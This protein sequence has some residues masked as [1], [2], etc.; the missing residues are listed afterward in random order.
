MDKRLILSLII[1]SLLFSANFVFAQT[2]LTNPLG[3]D[4]F[5]DLFTKIAETIAALIGALGTIMIVLA[6]IFYLTSAGSP[7]KM[8]KAKTTL[9]YAIIGIAIAI[10]AG[11]I[12][13]VIKEAITASG[14]TC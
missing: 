9:I 7:E 2:V 8:T 5:C 1:V 4:N 10:S 13:A 6:G 14:G 11:T 12:V 3:V